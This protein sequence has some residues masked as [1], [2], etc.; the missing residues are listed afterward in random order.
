MVSGCK[1]NSQNYKRNS[2]TLSKSTEDHLKEGISRLH[3]L[4]VI[5]DGDLQLSE[6]LAIIR[7]L[8]DKHPVEDFW[9]PKDNQSRARVDEYFDWA[10]HNMN[11]L[12]ENARAPEMAFYRK[13]QD[14]SLIGENADD[15]LVRIR[16]ESLD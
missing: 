13:F 8:A 7:Y 6:S 14:P 1:K 10:S 2:R 12:G 9:Y 4:P 5:H 15:D 3:Q 16:S 11:T